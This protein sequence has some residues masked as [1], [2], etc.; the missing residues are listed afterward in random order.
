MRSNTLP[1]TALV[2][3]SFLCGCQSPQTSSPPAPLA[4]TVSKAKRKIDL[5]TRNNALGLLNEL[6]NEE[7]HVSK[8]LLIKRETDAL[9]QLINRIS[10]AA[11][12]GADQLKALA[13]LNPDLDFTSTAL[14][15]GEK[16]TR[17]SIAKAKQH[18][19]LHSKGVEFEFQ[20]LL[21]QAEALNYGTHLALVAA[22]N[23]P[24]P[25]HAQQFAELSARLQVL[26]EQV[27]ALIRQRK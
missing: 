27:L 7:K 11:G 2:I 15:E 5:A 23:E 24:Q 22:E 16:A 21:T 25:E 17:A 20:L 14:P 26:H 18:T 1:L 8:L 6:L 10:D 4:A 13:K 12:D 3:L 19:L 9:H